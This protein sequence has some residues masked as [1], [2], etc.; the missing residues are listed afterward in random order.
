[1]PRIQACC[2]ALSCFCLLFRALLP[3]PPVSPAPSPVLHR[4]PPTISAFPYRK[5]CHNETKQCVQTVSR[6]GVP[7]GAFCSCALHMVLDW[8]CIASGW[9]LLRQLLLSRL[10][11]RPQARR[12]SVLGKRST[13]WRPPCQAHASV[14]SAASSLSVCSG[15]PTEMRM[16]LFSSLVLHRWAQWGEQTVSGNEQRA[17]SDID[18]TAQC[19]RPYRGI[20]ER[21]ACALTAAALPRHTCSGG[22]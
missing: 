15:R 1:M 9:E 2:A 10:V 22:P 20:R 16:K 4:S 11:G 18:H 6:E 12:A 7:V 13:S 5:G 14:A 21:S 8:A 17:E 19:S 3:Q